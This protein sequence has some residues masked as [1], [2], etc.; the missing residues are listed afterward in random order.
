MGSFRR[1]PRLD[2]HPRPG[3]GRSSVDG[4]QRRRGLAEARPLLNRHR[5]HGEA[6]V[7]IVGKQ[8]TGDDTDDG[9]DPPAAG[10]EQ[11]RTQGP[12]SVADGIVLALEADERQRRRLVGQEVRE[13]QAPPGREGT[14]RRCERG[15]V[16]HEARIDQQGRPDHERPRRALIEQAQQAELGGSGEDC[17]G[18]RDAE[19]VGH[20]ALGD[21]DAVDQA[22]RQ[23]GQAE[24]NRRSCA[25]TDRSIVPG[26]DHSSTRPRWAIGTC[27]TIERSTIVVR[28]LTTES[29]GLI[30][31]SRI[32][33]SSP[34][35]ATRIFNR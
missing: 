20:P 23:C 12:S 13:P 26:V 22:E 2:F 17:S 35:L 10:E 16:Q 24:G 8:I 18:R 6:D 11:A 34:V 7:E 28:T 21:C 32:E 9:A 1:P 33:F 19:P 27:S 3:T 29:I 5:G 14:K 4:R 15:A 25:A 30:S 31:R